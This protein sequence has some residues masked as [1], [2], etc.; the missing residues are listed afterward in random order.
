VGLDGVFAVTN[1]PSYRLTI[2][3]SD[4]ESARIV[5]TTGQSGNPFDKHYSDL[6]DRWLRG[7]SL[8]LPFSRSAVENGEA[9]RLTLEPTRSRPR[10]SDEPGAS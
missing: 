4:L 6:V 9:S 5:Q 7:D 2:D 10:P 8:P 3:M 1:G